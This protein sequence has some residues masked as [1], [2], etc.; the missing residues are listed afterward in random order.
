MGPRHKLNADRDELGL[1]EQAETS[2]EE[3][4]FSTLGQKQT[5]V[6]F[7]AEENPRKIEQRNAPNGIGNE[8]QEYYN[9][10]CT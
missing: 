7:T 5:C 6:C 2:I 4:V 9:V 8:A 3:Q 1:S 10:D